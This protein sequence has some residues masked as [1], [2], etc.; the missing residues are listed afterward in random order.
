MGTAGSIL[1]RSVIQGIVRQLLEEAK[2]A[3]ANGG[4]TVALG[5]DASAKVYRTGDLVEYFSA[6]H[7]AWIPARVTCTDGSG[8]IMVDVKPDTWTATE[9]QAW[10]IRPRATPKV[11]A[12]RPPEAP[13]PPGAIRA[14][15]TQA[16]ERMLDQVEGDEG[17]PD[18][19]LVVGE[20]ELQEFEG[21]AESPSPINRAYSR[22]VASGA[23]KV[24][25]APQIGVAGVRAPFDDEC[26]K[27]YAELGLGEG[28]M[29]DARAS[30]VRERADK[31]LTVHEP[32]G[33]ANEDDVEK[34]D[35]GFSL[36]A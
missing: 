7:K 31:K 13:K 21:S 25:A 17:S 6:T 4:K 11:E 16:L 9:Q 15:S 27:L 29:S 1:E 5:E 28:S 22:A 23:V 19:L 34:W 35:L 18:N 10:Q 20:D 12:A 14:C 33:I 26:S 8:R 2:A 30:P 36:S 3:Q 24:S 32:P